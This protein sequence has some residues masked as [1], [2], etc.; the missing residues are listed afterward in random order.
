MLLSQAFFGV[1]LA[2]NFANVNQPSDDEHYLMSVLWNWFVMANG[3]QK[4]AAAFV[5][6]R[7]IRQCNTI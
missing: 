3:A 6:G 1:I 4:L 2:G 5:Q 7:R